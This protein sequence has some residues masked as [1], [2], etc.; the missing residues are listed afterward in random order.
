MVCGVGALQSEAGRPRC[1][2]LRRRPCRRDHPEGVHRD[3]VAVEEPHDRDALQH[4][5]DPADRDHALDPGVPGRLP[6][7]TDLAHEAP[8]V[9]RPG[10]AAYESYEV[11]RTWR[12]LL[13]A[14]CTLSVACQIQ[15]SGAFPAGRPSA[16]S[17]GAR[18][19]SSASS[20]RYA[21]PFPR[22]ARRS[23]SPSARRQRQLPSGLPGELKPR[24]RA[25]G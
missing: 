19:V 10:A 1:R 4:D 3:M 16:A 12:G 24:L 8:L 25:R 22:C 14:E 15:I 2:G 7:T 21:A 20:A 5:E 6:R 9:I 17:S 23:R 11:R 13:P 18:P